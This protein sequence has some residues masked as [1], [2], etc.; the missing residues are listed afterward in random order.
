VVTVGEVVHGLEL[1]VDD[2]DAGL[3]GAA[4]DLLDI[5]GRLAL[6]LQLVEDLLGRL[7]GSLRV[8]L[9]CRVLVLVQKAYLYIQGSLGDIPG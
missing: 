8:E 2:A 6:C 9:S 7:D 4:G 1:L 3:V 5:S